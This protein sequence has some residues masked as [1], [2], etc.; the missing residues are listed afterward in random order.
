MGNTA[1]NRLAPGAPCHGMMNR[2]LKEHGEMLK[3]TP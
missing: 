3:N 1:N 2:S